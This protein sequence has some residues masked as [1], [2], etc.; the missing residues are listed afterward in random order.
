M[1]KRILIFLL[2]V[3]M[4]VP[5]LVA[6]KKSKPQE[7]QTTAPEETTPRREYSDKYAVYDDL[8]DLNFGERTVTIA[9]V[10]RTWYDDEV[11]SEGYT[12]D[13]VK[14][15]IFSR[16]SAVEERLHIFIESV[17]FKGPGVVQ[18]AVV[19]NLEKDILSGTLTYDL[20]QSP[21]Y[22]SASYTNRNLFYNLWNVEALDLNNKVYWSNLFN[23]TASIGKGQ[24]MATG[25]ISLSFYRFIFATLVNNRVLADHSN[26]PDLIEVVKDGEWTLEYQK[27]LASQFYADK[28]D[29]GK[30]AQDDFGLVTSDY[31]NVDPYWSACDLP[32]L[33]KGSDGFYTYD[34]DVERV[35]NAVDKILAL[36]SEDGTFCYQLDGKHETG[37]GEQIAIAEKFARGGALMAT[38][39]LI[40]LENA[41]IRNMQDEYTVLPMPKYDE[42]QN[43]YYSY[44]HDSFTTVSI[45]SVVSDEEAEVLGSVLEALASESYRTVTPKYYEI[46]LKTR[47]VDNPESAE[48]LDLITQNV[49][50]DAAIVYM[51]G[52]TVEKTTVLTILRKI[53]TDYYRKGISPTVASSFSSFAEGI[54]EQLRDYQAMIRQMQNKGN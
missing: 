32:V 5:C 36:F 23:E 25:A 22:A 31:L 17:R 38:L 47:Y 3:A 41:A 9:N 8:G 21:S 44:I 18:F 12:G 45:P 35:S 24:Y 37:N 20:V 7:P 33:K 50:L 49:K 53:S 19:N 54:E 2:A 40:E 13:I 16:N 43:N 10:D 29:S 4:S 26:S 48:M 6:C 52:L 34:L 51:H 11:A 1:A 27:T 30:D 42:E 46:A 14:D 15:A 28:G 39:R